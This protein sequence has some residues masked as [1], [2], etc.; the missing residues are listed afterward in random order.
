MLQDFSQEKIFA[1]INGQEM[2][3]EFDF[4]ALA[5]LEKQTEIRRYDFYKKVFNEINKLSIKEATI[6][7]YAGLIKHNENITLK[8]IGQIKS[9]DEIIPKIL[10][11][12]QEIFLQPEV[13]NQI[14]FPEE[15]KRSEEK[16][17]EP[18]R[19]YWTRELTFALTI[20]HWSKEQY[21]QS[22]PRE[23]YAFY[24]QHLINQGLYKTKQQIAEEKAK[25]QAEKDKKTK[26]SM[27]S[28]MQGIR[29]V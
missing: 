19:T 29:R 20:L 3:V 1:N 18:D 4:N 23:F 8:E 22:N 14:Y 12:Y 25:E 2:L 26:E 11:A 10:R 21:W 24:W 15:E 16:N 28:L 9:F 27:N 17:P 6:L 13:Y 5:C 7:I